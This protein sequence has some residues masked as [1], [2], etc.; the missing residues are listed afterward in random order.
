MRVCV[1]AVTCHG[2]LVT[3]SVVTGSVVTGSAVPEQWALGQLSAVGPA[4]APQAEPQPGSSAQDC[5]HAPQSPHA[6]L[7]PL[8]LCTTRPQPV[9]YHVL[10]VLSSCDCYIVDAGSASLN[11]LSCCEQAASQRNGPANRMC[12]DKLDRCS[13]DIK[14]GELWSARCMSNWRCSQC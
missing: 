9:N 3:G 2:E 8:R 6:V 10:F 12:Q 13:L 5:W 14:R 4:A 11:K 1:C 7:H